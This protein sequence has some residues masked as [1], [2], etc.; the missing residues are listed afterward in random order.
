[1]ASG[2]AIGMS[3]CNYCQFRMIQQR[4]DQLKLVVSQIDRPLVGCPKGVDVYVH[5]KWVNIYLL[6]E[7]DAEQYF[8][9]WYAELPDECAC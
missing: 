5:P 3:R 9:A 2:M 1:M 6:A 4:A 8:K 7:E